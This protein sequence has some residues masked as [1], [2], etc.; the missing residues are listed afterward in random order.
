MLQNSTTSVSSYVIGY[1][2]DRWMD[3]I[4]FQVQHY[5]HSAGDGQDAEAR[6]DSDLQG[7]HRCSCEGARDTRKDEVEESDEGA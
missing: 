3:L 4:C 5:V 6:R 2:I 1:L 7:L